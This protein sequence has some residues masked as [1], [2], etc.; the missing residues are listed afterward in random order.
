MASKTVG[1]QQLLTSEKKAAEMIGEAR[2]RKNKRLKAAKDEAAVEVP[3]VT[4]PVSITDGVFVV[5]VEVYRKEQE[6]AFASYEAGHLGNKA[7]IQA[8]IQ[9]DTE[10]TM[11]TMGASVE[12]NKEAVGSSRWPFTGR[13]GEEWAQV[14]AELLQLVSD[15]NVEVHQ[16]LK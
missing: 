15:I 1:I 5:Q 8:R 13:R 9:A 11:K 7:D 10:A 14:L 16:N 3:I 4:S 2:K 6:A 12:D